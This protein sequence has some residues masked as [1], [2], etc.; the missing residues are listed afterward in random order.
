MCVQKAFLAI[1]MFTDTKIRLCDL[2]MLGG[3]TFLT[4]YTRRQE[5]MFILI[6]GFILNR[7]AISMF[8]KYTKD[9]IEKYEKKAVQPIVMITIIAIVCVKNHMI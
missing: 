1:L 6:C 2:F 4:F 7:L 5:S 8:S 9:S 3:L